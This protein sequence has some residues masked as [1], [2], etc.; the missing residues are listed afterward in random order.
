[1]HGGDHM[2]EIRIYNKQGLIVCRRYAW[3]L[4]TAWE[5]V[6]WYQDA[7]VVTNDLVVRSRRNGEW[8]D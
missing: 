2:Y 5:I 6:A 8:R 3:D 1:M 7:D 4:L